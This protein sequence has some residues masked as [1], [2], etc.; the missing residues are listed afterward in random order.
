MEKK[1]QFRVYHRKTCTCMC[2]CTVLDFV[3]KFYNDVYFT[4]LDTQTL[5]AFSHSSSSLPGPQAVYSGKAASPTRSAYLHTI[6]ALCRTKDLTASLLPYFL[7]IL[8]GSVEK[9][10]AKSAQAAALEEGLVAVHVLL[11]IQE[12]G[13]RCLEVVE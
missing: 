1:C 12:T 9:A 4:N 13:E 6:P 11:E 5:A 2:M 8:H 3:D 7:P 10:A